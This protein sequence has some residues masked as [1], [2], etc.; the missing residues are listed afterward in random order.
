MVGRIMDVSLM[1]GDGTKR[2]AAGEVDTAR[3]VRRRWHAAHDLPAG[4]VLRS[5]DIVLKRPADGLPPSFDLVGRRIIR[6][7]DR[8]Q[9]ILAAAV[10]S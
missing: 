7:V 8:D 4:T 1:L 2:P 10:E 3:L 5:D 9:P 6:P